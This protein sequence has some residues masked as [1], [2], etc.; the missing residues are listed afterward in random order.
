MWH[1]NVNV[2]EVY[3]RNVTGDVRVSITGQGMRNITGPPD[4]VTNIANVIMTAAAN[5][6]RVDVF[7]GLGGTILSARMVS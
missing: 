5:G 1:L 3:A 6:L 7:I 2:E 4:A